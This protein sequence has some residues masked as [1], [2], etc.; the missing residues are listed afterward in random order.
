MFTKINKNKYNILKNIILL[1]T[2]ATILHAN[3][4][5]IKEARTDVINY[6][7]HYIRSNFFLFFLVEDL[8]F[9]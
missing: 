3:K 8:S 7:F 1:Y 6:Y 4:P 2:A 9:F 5:Y